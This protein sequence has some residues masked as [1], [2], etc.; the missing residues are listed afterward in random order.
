MTDEANRTQGETVGPDQE[1]TE[2]GDQDPATR[3][4]RPDG[5]MV[6]PTDPDDA[7]QEMGESPDAAYGQREGQAD[8]ET[9]RQP[10]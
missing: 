1:P 8:S 4:P 9:G 7:S 3:A 2:A 6:Q 5:P 10:T